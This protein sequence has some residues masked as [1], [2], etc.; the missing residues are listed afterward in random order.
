VTDA[1]GNSAI[2]GAD[3]AIAVLDE[4]ET[5]SHHRTRFTVGN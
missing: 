5:P 1:E 2:G 4:I 3:F